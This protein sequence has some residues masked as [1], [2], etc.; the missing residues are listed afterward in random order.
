M[1]EKARILFVD[2]EERIV[3][4]LKIM[5][6]GT[7]EVFTATNGHQALQIVAANQIHVV[8]SDQRM[9]EMLGID[10]LAKVRELSPNTMRMLLTG[11]SDLAAIVGSVNDGEVFR[12]I[13]KPWDQ[14]EIKKTI[15]DAIEIAVTT[16][17]S[18]PGVAAS[19][20]QEVAPNA[21]A[22]RKAELL[23][24]D[25]NA[26]DRE[27]ISRLF[28]GDYRTFGAASIAD[29]VKLLEQQNIGVIVSESN[30][31][32]EDAGMLLKILKQK[33]PVITTVMLTGNAD[34]DEVIKLINQAQIYRFA[35]KPIRKAA[36]E[37]AVASAA[38]QHE[39]LV[40]DPMLRARHKVVQTA[41]TEHSTLAKSI[42][43]GVA[44]LAARWGFFG[45]QSS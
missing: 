20:T 32:G 45:R 40:S 19:Y 13:S 43:R 31:A 3:N 17:Q 15:A 6:R 4:L 41:E 29:A 24:I 12:F 42:M 5:F 37:L 21:V 36:L 38:K 23:I 25:D 18:R 39:R 1:S 10:L 35:T 9:P 11:Y 33:Y 7:Y 2:D 28:D 16:W 14:E 8:V 27:W 44:G 34:A 26:M 30:V 22:K